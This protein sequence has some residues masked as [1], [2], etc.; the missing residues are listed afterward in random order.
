MAKRKSATKVRK[1]KLYAPVSVPQITRGEKHEEQH[2]VADAEGV[3]MVPSTE[4]QDFLA[5]G[6][7]RTPQQP[8]AVSNVAPTE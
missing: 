6:C 8:A 5:M 3:I 7:S 2:Y 1:V 4:V